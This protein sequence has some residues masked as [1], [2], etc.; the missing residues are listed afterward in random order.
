MIRIIIADDHKLV[1]EAWSMLLGRDKR[2]DVIAICE[3]GQEVID[4]I[5][6]SEADII[7]MDIN[8]EPINGIEA[9]RSIRKFN[10]DIKIIGIS[11][12]TDLPY[13]KALMENGANGYVTKNSPGAEMIKAIFEVIEGNVFYCKEISSFQKTTD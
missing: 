5:K 3:N 13:V 9:T 6:T 4:Y 8:M 11:V 1:R 7:L 2:L 12:H 10:Q